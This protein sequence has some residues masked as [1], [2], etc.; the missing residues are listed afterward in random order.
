MHYRQRDFDIELVLDKPVM[1]HLSSYC[2]EAP[3]DSPVW[4]LWEEERVWLFGTAED[5]FVKR[6]EREPRCTIG[7]VDFSLEDGI[8][9]HVGLRGEARIDNICAQRR[10]CF[11][12]RYLGHDSTLWNP[13]FKKNIVDPLDVMME[14]IPHSIVAKD[15]SFFKTGPDLAS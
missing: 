4:F 2:P 12:G 7:I 6:L 14:I 13:W 8:L 5:S 9:R 11:V 15:V 10:D 3:R 1:A